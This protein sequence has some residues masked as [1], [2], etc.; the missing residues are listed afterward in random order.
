[1]SKIL[2]PTRHLPVVLLLATIASAGYLVA[3]NQGGG[4][5]RV[6]PDISADTV[7]NH[8]IPIEEADAMT[9][10]FRAALDTLDKKVPNFH[11]SMDFGH[12]EAFPADIFR[13]LLR[14]KSDSG[15]PAVGIRIYYGRDPNGKIRQILVPYDSNGNDI[16]THYADVSNPPK[17]GAHVE[18]LKVSN[19]QALENGARCPTV[20]GNDSSGLN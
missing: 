5:P 8:V 12:A 6:E 7:K 17:Q 3:C 15:S 13:E 1:M 19:G 2:K 10:N 18:A 4:G 9:A 11:D 14:Q 20:C 16:V